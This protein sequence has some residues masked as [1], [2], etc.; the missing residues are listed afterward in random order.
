VS[1][2]PTEQIAPGATNSEPSAPLVVEGLSVELETRVGRVGAVRDVSL[3]ARSGEV[4]ALLGESGSG[5]TLT[6]LAITGLLDPAARVSS[7]RVRVDGVDV[8]KLSN[9]ERL[10]YAGQ[11][12]SMVFQEAQ[13]VLN[14]VYTVGTALAEPLRIH[15]GMSAGAAKR[16]AVQ[17]MERVGVPEASSRVGSYPHEFSGGLLQRILI[18]IAIALHP[19]VLIADE[20]TT[21]LDVTVQAQILDLLRTLRHEEGMAVVL[22]T[23]D[24]AVAVAEAANVAVM[25][26]GRIV[27]SGPTNAVVTT[28]RHPYTRALLKAVPRRLLPGQRLNPIPGYPPPVTAIPSGCAFRSRCPMAQ[29]ICAVTRPPL[30]LIDPNHA[31]ACHFATE[32][33]GD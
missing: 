1:P 26:A 28:P 20:P 29:E 8:L 17:L 4:T 2:Q 6:A 21:A 25:Y 19:S 14:P 11:K 10:S 31:S 5:K 12:I 22:I 7:G 18:G 24:L 3:V 33:S 32:V 13:S 9:S 27:E 30:Q 16:E 23:H 15:R